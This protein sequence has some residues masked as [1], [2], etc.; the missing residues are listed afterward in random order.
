MKNHFVRSMMITAAALALSAAANAQ[1]KLIADVPFAFQVRGATLPAG[2]YVVESALRGSTSAITVRNV[3]NG[4]KVFALTM[5]AVKITGSNAHL[6]F[7]CGDASGCALS[8]AWDDSGYGRKIPTPRLK[9]A[10]KELIA[11]VPLRR[12]AD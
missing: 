4:R 3:H 1:E 11:S 8:E 6:T 10:E 2:Q 9:P 12:S 7:R 5:P